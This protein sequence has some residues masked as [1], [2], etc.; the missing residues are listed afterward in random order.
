MTMPKKI[1]F[2]LFVLST[3]LLVPRPG[4]VN[5]TS[6]VNR[7]RST[8]IDLSTPEQAVFYF[9]EA[10]RIGDDSMLEKVLAP[11]AILPEFNPVQKLDQPNPS[12]LGAD[13][14]KIRVIDR[15][16]NYLDSGFVIKPGDVEIYVTVRFSPQMETKDSGSA[17]LDNKPCF[18]T[19]KIDHQWKIVAV[20]PFWPEDPKG[21]DKPTKEDR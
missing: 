4:I 15:K 2:L 9:Y 17:S 13:I 18:L 19:R 6:P 16:I 1:L 12:V 14:N 11:D 21:T 10:F 8:T 7:N 3:L 20:Y 5:G